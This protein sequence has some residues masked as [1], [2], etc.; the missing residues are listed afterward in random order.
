MTSFIRLGVVGLML[1][2]CSDSAPSCKDAVTSLEQHLKGT[3]LRV[4]V[5][6]QMCERDKYSANVRRCLSVARSQV[7]LEKCADAQL[8]NCMKSAGGREAM[9]DGCKSITSLREL[10]VSG[11]LGLRSARDQAFRVI[12]DYNRAFDRWSE[13]SPDKRCPASLEEL[14]GVM[15]QPD[16]K[17][18][19][20]DPWGSPFTMKCDAKDFRVISFGPDQQPG[21]DDDVPRR[22]ATR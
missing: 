9:L 14:E 18:I 20:T 11:T 8:Q 22:T 17:A 2:G 7:A 12:E 4:D 6:P 21:T 10:V 15:D 16:L 5:S 19:R 3:G 1:V 13:R